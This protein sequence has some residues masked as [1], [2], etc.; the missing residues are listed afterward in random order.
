MAENNTLDL[1][2]KTEVK[3]SFWG[4]DHLEGGPFQCTSSLEPLL[5]L[6]CGNSGDILEF[7]KM[8]KD[9]VK[10]CLGARGRLAQVGESFY[11]YSHSKTNSKYSNK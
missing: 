10:G 6:G 8:A 1:E 2:N 5:N 3:R 4:P 11:S 9:K 7:L